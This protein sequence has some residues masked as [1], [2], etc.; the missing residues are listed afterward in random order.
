MVHS[1]FVFDKKFSAAYHFFNLSLSLCIGSLLPSLITSH[2]TQ[3]AHRQQSK[4]II[5]IIAQHRYNMYIPTYRRNN[6]SLQEKCIFLF[7]YQANHMIVPIVVVTAAAGGI[8]NVSLLITHT[9]ELYSI[10]HAQK[11]TLLIISIFIYCVETKRVIFL[12]YNTRRMCQ[13]KYIGIPREYIATSKHNLQ[14]KNLMMKKNIGIIQMVCVYA[15]THC[16][17]YWEIGQYNRLRYKYYWL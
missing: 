12:L 1:R 17:A 9:H 4:T 11:E 2:C 3:N 6:T 8:H 16:G 15:R 14:I 5:L 13:L 10:L 7:Q